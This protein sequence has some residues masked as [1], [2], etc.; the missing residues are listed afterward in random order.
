MACMEGPIPNSHKK[1]PRV[2]LPWAPRWRRGPMWFDL[3]D[4]LCKPGWPRASAR[5]SLELRGNSRGDP[6]VPGDARRGGRADDAPRTRRLGKAGLAG[7][8][9][10]RPASIDATLS[11]RTPLNSFGA[12]NSAE[13]ACRGFSPL[14]FTEVARSQG[15]G[16]WSRSGCPS[17]E[18]SGNE[19]TP[20]KLG[21]WRILVGKCINLSKEIGRT[22]LS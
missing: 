8:W 12:L 19:G 11:S 14:F 6:L 4:L 5:S 1:A 13:V 9:R 2:S 22:L 15:S 18:L 20:Q 16:P 17:G 7:I 3:G 21:P 10:R